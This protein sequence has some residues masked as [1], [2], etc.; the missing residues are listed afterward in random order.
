MKCETGGSGKCLEETRLAKRPGIIAVRVHLDGA[1]TK[2]K[3]I[4]VLIVAAARSK[5]QVGFPNNPSGNHIVLVFALVQC[6]WA[7][8]EK[9]EALVHSSHFRKSTRTRTEI[10]T[11]TSTLILQLIQK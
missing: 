11:P 3:L 5:S 9:K 1:K 6:K 2:V 10:T 7:L 4:F 8:N